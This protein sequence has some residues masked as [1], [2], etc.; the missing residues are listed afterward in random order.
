MTPKRLRELITSSPSTAASNTDL[1]R[2][3]VLVP[4]FFQEEIL[5]IL[6]TQRTDLVKD[7]QGQI[8]FP[9]GV[10]HPQDAHIVATALREAQEE[11]GLEPGTVEVLGA[12]RPISTI[13]GYFIHSFVGLIPYPYTFRLNAQ[14]VARLIILPVMPL[15][16]AGRWS[17]RPYEWQGQTKQA[18]FCQYDDITVWG[19]TARILIDLLTRLHPAFYPP[20][21]G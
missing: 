15:L 9:G 2:A 18:F 5:Q 17:S 14:E 21:E 11:I 12:L 4:L 19:A 8:S 13:T 20:S 3:A 7:H 16:E 1:I 10:H 6:F